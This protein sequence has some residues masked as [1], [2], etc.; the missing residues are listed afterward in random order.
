MPRF[1][2]EKAAVGEEEICLTGEDAHHVARSLRMAVGDTIVVCDMQGN[3]HTCALTQIRD[4][5]VD[6]KILE[7]QEGSTEPP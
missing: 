4:D 1:F 2:V 3:A 7:S 5:R 6:A